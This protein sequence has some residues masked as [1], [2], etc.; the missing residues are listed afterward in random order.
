M[1]LVA[2]VRPGPADHARP[3]LEDRARRRRDQAVRRS[4]VHERRD[5]EAVER[6]ADANL[7]CQSLG[8]EA[9]RRPVMIQGIR[10]VPF[11]DGR[12]AR[13]DRSVE[14]VLEGARGRNPA[15]EDVGSDTPRAGA[16]S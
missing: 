16:I 2:E 10:K 1:A 11:T 12:V 6:G 4:V 5:P 14:L 15:Q 8:T 9:E 3:S 13:Q 7:L